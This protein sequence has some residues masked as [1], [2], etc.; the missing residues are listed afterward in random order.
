[1]VLRIE[2]KRLREQKGM[3]QRE[4]AIAMGMGLTAIQKYEY[5]NNKSIP[6][7]TLE[8]FCQVLDC[9]PSELF[10]EPN[11]N[12]DRVE[13][14]IAVLTKLEPLADQK[15]D[16]SYKTKLYYGIR[17]AIAILQGKSQ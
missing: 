10:A 12:R 5:G 16:A 13:S 7:A 9:Q 8:K 1:M 6:F 17:D 3:S 14:A 4:L 2:L 15:W 11:K